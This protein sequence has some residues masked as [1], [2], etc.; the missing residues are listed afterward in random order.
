MKICNVMADTFDVN[1][2]IGTNS[3][4]APLNWV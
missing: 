3:I 4:L 1:K 2:N